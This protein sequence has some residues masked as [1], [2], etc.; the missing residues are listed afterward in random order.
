MAENK[1][2][3]ADPWFTV[4]KVD[5]DTYRISEYRH[6]EETHAYLLIGTE[7]ALLVDSGL[8]IGNIGTVVAA[9]TTK[10]IVVVA[11]HVH[12]D[13]IGGHR[14]FSCFYVHAAEASW[15]SGSF[16][17]PVST[18]RK[19]LAMA[20]QFPQSFSCE[21]YEVFSGIP[22]RILNDGDTLELGER[23][24]MVVHTPGHSPGHMCFWEPKQGYLFVGDLVYQGILY[25]HYP[26]TDPEQYWVSLEKV[27]TLPVRRLF[28]AH[29][30]S[31]LPPERLCQVRDAFRY[32]KQ[33]DMLHHGSGQHRFD[34]WAIQL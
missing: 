1:P 32:L 34:G 19:Q 33:N 23:T 12:W 21:A 10:P 9:L 5:A 17:L 13:H 24:L 4:T 28:P 16:P 8:G 26:S 2:L 14:C 11:T 18:V 22:S 15:I 3:T 31:E 7:R 27:A 25:A 20:P 6:P 30:Q 29:H